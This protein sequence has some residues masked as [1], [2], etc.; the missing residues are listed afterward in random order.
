MAFLILGVSV[1][2]STS[3]KYVFSQAPSP[4]PNLY[5]HVNIDYTLPTPAIRPDSLFWPVQALA[6]RADNTAVDCLENA[7][8]RLVSGAQMVGQGKVE[9]GYLVLEKASQYLEKSYELSR[10]L[11]DETE[12]HDFLHKISL[13]SLKHRE[14]LELI[15]STAPD[16]GRAVV[17][18]ILDAPKLVYEKSS[19]DLNLL[20]LTPP[21]YPF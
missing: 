20:G 10:G 12:R 11:K 8:E 13:A 4:A 2:K 1:Y 14:V 15:L 7:D 5:N 9:E 17:T 19:E 16:D 6:D 3:V 18:T 21:E